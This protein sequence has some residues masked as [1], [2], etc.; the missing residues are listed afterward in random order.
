MTTPGNFPSANPGGEDTWII[1]DALKAWLENQG[2]PGVGC[3]EL[4]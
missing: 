2:I 1:R 4:T 3:I